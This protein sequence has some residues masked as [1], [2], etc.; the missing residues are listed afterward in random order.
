[1]E[2]V[3]NQALIMPE[4]SNMQNGVCVC[5]QEVFEIYK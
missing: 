3:H 5:V 2:N 4:V 1:L